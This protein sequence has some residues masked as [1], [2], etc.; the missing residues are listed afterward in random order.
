MVQTA[1]YPVDTHVSKEQETSNAQ[2]HPRSAWNTN[3]WAHGPQSDWLFYNLF[4]QKQKY[5]ID[6]YYQLTSSLSIVSWTVFQ[7][8]IVSPR[9]EA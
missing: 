4:Q 1:V 5:L 6:G 2:E 8:T 3:Q 9:E 7:V